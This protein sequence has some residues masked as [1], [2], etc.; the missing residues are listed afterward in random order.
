MYRSHWGLREIPFRGGVESRFYYESP[1]HEEALARMQFLVE[2]HHRL[3]IL[4]GIGGGGKSLLLEVFD[5]QL[6]RRGA[7]VVHLSLVGVDVRELLWCAAADLGANPDRQATEFQLWRLVL[8]CLAANRVHNCDT[9]FLLDDL[10]ECDEHVLAAVQRLLE[11]GKSSA[12]RLTIIAAWNT[13]QL[14]QL[15]P[16]LLAQAELRIEL[17]AWEESDTANYLLQSVLQAGGHEP[18]FSL[19]AIR[20]LHQLSHGVP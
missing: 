9:V 1:A 16:R 2:E 7:Q 5:R 17:A 12:A 18:P 8:D 10:D 19:A 11:A 20:R 6:R 14:R 4:S 3:G 15:P 13:D